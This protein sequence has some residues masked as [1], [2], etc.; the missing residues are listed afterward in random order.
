MVLGVLVLA[1]GGYYAYVAFL[2]PP[3]PPPPLPPRKVHPVAKPPAPGSS[4]GGVLKEAVSAP[5]K[6][7]DAAE[8][9]ITARRQ[10]EQAR[11]DALADGKDVPGTP[12]AAGPAPKGQPTTAS[13]TAQLAPGVTATTSVDVVGG[14][15]SAAFRTWVANARISGVF[16]GTPARALINNRL[17]HAGQLVDDTLGISFVGVDPKTNAIIFRDRS[18][19]TV[20]RDF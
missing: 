20:S 3:P 17:Y 14:G 8:N 1:G 10:Q 5:G 11:V 16:Q 4:S 9:A 6:A 7:L 15:A 18:G 12:T 19:A 13:A 2:A